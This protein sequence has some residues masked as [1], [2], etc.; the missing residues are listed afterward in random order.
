MWY[1]ACPNLDE[2]TSGVMLMSPFS[3]SIKIFRTTF[4]VAIFLGVQLLA[5]AGLVLAHV[6]ILPQEAEPGQFEVFE[7]WI[8]H[9]CEHSP[10]NKLVLEIPDGVALVR[11][12]VKPDWTIATKTGPYSEPVQ[13]FGTSYEEGV[14]EITWSGGSVPT[15]YMDSFIFSAFFPDQPSTKLPFRARQHCEGVSEPEEFTLRVNL[16]PAAEKESSGGGG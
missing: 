6:E 13:V 12:K 14:R 2:P 9:G 7:I 16:R 15:E 8:Y 4:L 3:S 1:C 10:T 5:G 11:P